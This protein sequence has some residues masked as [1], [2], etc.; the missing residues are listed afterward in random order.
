MTDQT[1]MAIVLTAFSAIII[2]WAYYNYTLRQT[3]KKVIP[4]FPIKKPA[5]KKLAVKKPVVKKPIAKKTTKG[6]K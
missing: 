1:V 3:K 4:K 2:A 5:V 6:K